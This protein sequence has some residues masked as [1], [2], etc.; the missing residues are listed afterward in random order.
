[1]NTGHP[2]YQNFASSQESFWQCMFQTPTALADSHRSCECAI[3]AM[4]EVVLTPITISCS[5]GA[6]ETTQPL[7]PGR[8]QFSLMA[9]GIWPP[10]SWTFWNESFY[11]DQLRWGAEFRRFQHAGSNELKESGFQHFMHGI[12]HFYNFSYLPVGSLSRIF[13]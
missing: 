4:S 1:M 2:Q 11:S 5:C 3:R 7:K 12:C 8:S 13:Q 10:G 9:S 6:E